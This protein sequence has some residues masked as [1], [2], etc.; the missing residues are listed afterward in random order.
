[1]A[2]NMSGEFVLSADRAAVWAKLNDPAVLKTCIPGC[3][4]FEPT[5]ENAYRVVAKSKIGPVSVR[6]KGNIILSEMDP[7][8]S[9]RI[10]GQ[11]DGGISGFA[12]GGARVHLEDADGGHTK[13]SYD[14]EAE[15][16]GKIAQLGSRL[17][18]GVAKKNADEFFAN[19]AQQF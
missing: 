14:V 2:L 10:L 15:V 18:A 11:G 3:E 9:Y 13:L 12:K 5:D 7:P 4:E 17:I 1:M 19:F 16:G 6:F 8:N